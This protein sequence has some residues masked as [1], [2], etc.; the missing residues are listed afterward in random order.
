MMTLPLESLE[1]ILVPS[2]D[3]ATRKTFEAWESR[4]KLIVLLRASHISIIEPIPPEAMRVPSGDHEAVNSL[5]GPWCM[6]GVAITGPAVPVGSVCGDGV[7]V[8]T[9]AG[10]VLIPP[11]PD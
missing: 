3:H 7:D 9:L 10:G 6:R 11:V 1:A 8:F 4:V 2:G 5:S